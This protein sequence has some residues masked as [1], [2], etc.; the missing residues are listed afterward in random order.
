MATLAIYDSV[1]VDT[2]GNIVPNASVAVRREESNNELI[3]LY[4]DRG[5]LQQIT[6]PVQADSSG[7]VIFFVPGGAYKLNVSAVGLSLERRY[8]AIGTAAEHDFAAVEGIRWQ[9][10]WLTSTFYITQDAVRNGGTSY[11]ALQD[12]ISDSSNEPGVGSDYL[13][14]WDVLAEKGATGDVNDTDA[15]ILNNLST[16]P[17]APAAGKT[18]IYVRSGTVY[19]KDDNGVESAIGSSGQ[20]FEVFETLAAA[21]AYS[22]ITAPNYIQIL[23]YYSAGDLGGA[24]YKKRGASAPAD[25]QVYFSITLQNSSVVYYEFAERTI[26]IKQTGAK[27]DWDSND[28]VATDDT[29]AI[30]KAL[31]YAG[32][33]VATGTAAGEDW[34]GTVWVPKGGAKVAL[35]IQVPPYVTLKGE[36]RYA[37]RLHK[38]AG[39]AAFTIYLGDPSTHLAAF[40]CSLEDLIVS[41][42]LGQNCA[43]GAALVYSNNV[44][45]YG[46]VRHCS[47]RASHESAI[48]FETGYGGASGVHILDCELL[49]EGGAGGLTNNPIVHI[50]YGTTY[51]DMQRLSVAG[52]GN[53]SGGAAQRGIL[54]QGAGLYRLSCIHFEWCYNGLNINIGGGTVV[55]E[56]SSGGDGMNAVVQIES[57]SSSGARVTLARIQK[58]GATLLYADARSGKPSS[59]ASELIP[60]TII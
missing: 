40:D 8:V 1:V 22:P 28:S 54:L 26:N 48:R 46:G 14:Y 3:P 45:E 19:K 30:Q 21:Q 25:H 32:R 41:A 60:A 34:G 47:I 56:D 18:K 59:G 4:A 49:N 38:P 23:G 6:N 33:R 37:S 2:A 36:A 39:G 24:L 52:P 13:N 7:R 29:G 15:L 53:G 10:Q 42:T 5:G 11:V 31:N 12:H 58:N 20:A 35:T 9:Q 51:V 50:N 44:Q 16:A 57:T 55:L 27:M 17:A 43:S